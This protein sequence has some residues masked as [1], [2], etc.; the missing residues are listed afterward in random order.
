MSDLEA[1][2]STPPLHAE[3]RAA[4]KKAVFDNTVCLLEH[5]EGSYNNGQT[6]GITLRDPECVDAI[7]QAVADA[8]LTKLPRQDFPEKYSLEWQKMQAEG[9]NECLDAVTRV[10]GEL[11]GK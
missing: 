11:G 2:S 9:F 3:V 4:V 7:L 1:S 5:K 10:I 6:D 8:L